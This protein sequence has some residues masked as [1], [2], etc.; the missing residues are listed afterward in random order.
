MRICPT[1]DIEESQSVKS[2]HIEEKISKKVTFS[3][4]IDENTKN[5]PKHLKK[6]DKHCGDP[7]LR[8]PALC[9]NI[10]TSHTGK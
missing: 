2:K 6:C 7:Q 4:I 8:K 10:H 1:F 3:Q 5:T 9:K